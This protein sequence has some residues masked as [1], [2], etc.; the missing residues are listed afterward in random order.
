MAI[1]VGGIQNRIA[2]IVDLSPD[3]PT[4]GGDSWNLRMQYINMAQ[5]EAYQ[6]YDWKFLYKEYSTKTSTNSGNASITM[7]SDFRTLAGYP[8]ITYDEVNSAEFPEVRAQERFSKSASSNFVYF[9][10]NPGDNYTMVVNTNSGQLPSGASIFV[11]YYSS[12]V[13]LTTVTDVSM[14]PDVD[15]LV[16]R[17]VAFLWEASEDDRFP[18]AKAQAEKI[19]QRMLERENVFSEANNDESQVRTVEERR[20]GFRLGRD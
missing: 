10:G 1:N 16:S 9:L 12:G 2:S 4:I 14:I 18:Q 7:P 15:Y 6:L 3:A 13:S 19:L 8:K 17:S 5:S 11:P 20:Y